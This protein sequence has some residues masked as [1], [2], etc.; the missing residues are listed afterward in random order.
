[1]LAQALRNLLSKDI[2]SV[3]HTCSLTYGVRIYG[4]AVPTRRLATGSERITP[5]AR[6]RLEPFGRTVY[7]QQ[8]S[9][10]VDAAERRL[11]HCKQRLA[12]ITPFCNL[13]AR[14]LTIG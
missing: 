5:P 14:D 3:L 12:S 4:R 6:R 1:M 8:S 11:A 7:K 10:C 2:S 9:R 13:L